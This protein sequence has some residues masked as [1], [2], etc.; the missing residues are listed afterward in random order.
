MADFCKQCAA[1]LEF[2]A[3]FTGLFRENKVEPDG[4]KTGFYCLCESCVDAFII[5]DEGTCGNPN[6]KHDMARSLP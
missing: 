2:P 5:D 1:E 3:D 6:H 4:G